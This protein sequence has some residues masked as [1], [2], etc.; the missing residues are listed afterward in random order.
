MTQERQSSFRFKDNPE[1]DMFGIT[2]LVSGG[3]TNLQAIIDSIA[4][5]E[6]KSA[7]VFIKKVI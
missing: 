3:G 4:D 5:G 7:G 6:L 1:Q 2:V